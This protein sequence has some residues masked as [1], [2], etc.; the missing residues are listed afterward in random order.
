MEGLSTDRRGGNVAWLCLVQ[1]DTFSCFT[2]Q[3]GEL[4]PTIPAQ[5]D[6][7]LRGGSF[8][9]QAYVFVAAAA[10]KSDRPRARG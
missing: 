9:K 5:R 3:G 8:S 2:G 10:R 4:M 1:R 6:K 7:G